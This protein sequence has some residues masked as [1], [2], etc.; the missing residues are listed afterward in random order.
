MSNKLTSDGP[1]FCP[2]RICFF[3]FNDVVRVKV[4][5]SVHLLG[6]VKVVSSAL[7]FLNLCD[8]VDG[9][10]LLT[11]AVA[12][13]LW[14]WLS[15][16]R[17]HWMGHSCIQ[18]A[19][20]WMGQSCF[21]CAFAFLTSSCVQCAVEWLCWSMTELLWTPGIVSLVLFHQRVGR[22]SYALWT[23]GCFFW[24]TSSIVVEDCLWSVKWPPSLESN[25]LF[26]QGLR[27][28]H[29]H[30][31]NKVFCYHLECI[32]RLWPAFIHRKWCLGGFQEVVLRLLKGL[33]API[34]G[35]LELLGGLSKPLCRLLEA[36]CT[37]KVRHGD[38]F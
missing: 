10:L 7:L 38:V 30:F 37:Q 28:V 22:V 6:W 27:H 36:S 5:S 12:L 23:A 16:T 19:V 21:Q 3:V 31:C 2:L 32:D 4:V 34:G 15:A 25:F 1:K 24:L 13:Y 26:L 17:W 20:N 35:T 14:R 8:V 18:C 9:C 33:W 11:L 29:C